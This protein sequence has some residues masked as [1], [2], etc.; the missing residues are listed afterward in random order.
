MSVQMVK[1]V[2]QKGHTGDFLGVESWA[3]SLGYSEVSPA[4]PHLIPG[5]LPGVIRKLLSCLQ[6]H[7]T[8]QGGGGSGGKE[9]TWY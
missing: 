9:A 3:R 4:P 2:F 7:S 1:A 6:L 5:S 8:K